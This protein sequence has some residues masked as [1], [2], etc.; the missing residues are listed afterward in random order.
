MSRSVKQDYPPK[1]T[2][3][4][5]PKIGLVHSYGAIMFITDEALFDSMS[6]GDKEYQRKGVEYT[7]SPTAE[8]WAKYHLAKAGLLALQ[9]YEPTLGLEEVEV[10]IPRPEVHYRFTETHDEWLARCRALRQE[11]T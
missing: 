4:N 10:P 9:N 3:V 7:V 5:A 2:K 8:D 6:W 11:T 1:T